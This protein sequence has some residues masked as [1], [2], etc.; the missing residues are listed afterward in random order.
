[1]KRYFY[2]IGM[3]LGLFFSPAVAS[4]QDMTVFVT[5]T[6]YAG[7]IGGTGGANAE[8]QK[9]AEAAGLPGLYRAWVS[10]SSSDQPGST[11]VAGGAYKLL[12]DTVVADNW[13]DLTDGSLD[14]PIDRDEFNN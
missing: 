7:N 4:A 8:C 13:T 6:T 11:F 12:D 2:I 14:N 10:V 9:R 1:I 5:S 3:V